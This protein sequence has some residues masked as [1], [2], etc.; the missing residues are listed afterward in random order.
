MEIKLVESDERMIRAIA[1]QAEAERTR[2]VKIIHAEGELQVSEKL[3]AATQILKPQPQ[4]IQLLYLQKLT[5]IAG[6][7]SSTIVFPLPIDLI[8]SL[9]NLLKRVTNSNQQQT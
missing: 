3:L 4:A 6:D 5:E 1:Q 9:T 8:N 2:R 7:K